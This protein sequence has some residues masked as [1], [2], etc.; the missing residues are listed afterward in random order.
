ME[1]IGLDA[2]ERTGE[3]QCRHGLDPW[4][5]ESCGREEYGGW[6]APRQNRHGID[7]M[8]QDDPPTDA[9]G[10]EDVGR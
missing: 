3:P 9:R 5:C 7:W 10:R 1:D 2:H 4:D 6:F 8:D